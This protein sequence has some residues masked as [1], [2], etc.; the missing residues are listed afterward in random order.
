MNDRDLE[1]MHMAPQDPAEGAFPGTSLKDLHDQI[2]EDIMMAMAIDPDS[3]FGRRVFNPPK[4]V[5]IGT[6]KAEPNM[7]YERFM[8]DK[9]N[10]L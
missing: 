10:E 8:R 4:T 6:P 5:F 2:M 3:R 9:N 1:I 7:F